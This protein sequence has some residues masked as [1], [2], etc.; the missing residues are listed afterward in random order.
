MIG[1]PHGWTGIR[2]GKCYL[3]KGLECLAKKTCPMFVVECLNCPKSILTPSV[4]LLQA[5]LAEVQNQVRCAIHIAE[6][7]GQSAE[8]I[9]MPPGLRVNR[10]ADLRTDAAADV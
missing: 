7:I 3:I 2:I 8:R 1:H 9:G 6:N 4:E 5:A 10:S